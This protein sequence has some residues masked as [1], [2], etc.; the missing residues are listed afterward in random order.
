[1]LIIKEATSLTPLLKTELADLYPLIFGSLPAKFFSKFEFHSRFLL[2]LAYVDDKLVGFKIGYGQD[3]DLFYSWTG[4]V[5]A[6]YRKQGIARELMIRQH[7]WCKNSGYQRIETRTRNKFPQMINLNLKQGFHIVGTFTDTD[8]EPKII[9]R[10]Q[11][12]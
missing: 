6:D 10:K 4:G 3:S 11:L 1:M 12:H 8:K 5:H 7:E 2:L 9:L